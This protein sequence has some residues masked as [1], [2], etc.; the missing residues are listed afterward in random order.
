MK[1]EHGRYFIDADG[2]MFAHILN[3]LRVGQLPPSE[4]ASEVC[5]HAGYFGIQS[6]VE[7]LQGQVP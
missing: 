1:D 3:Y 2:P 6:L 5:R 4:V 7:K